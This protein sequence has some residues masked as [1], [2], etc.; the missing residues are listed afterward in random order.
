MLTKRAKDAAARLAEALD[1]SVERAIEIA[2]ED[3]LMSCG[4]AP[5]ER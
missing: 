4:D 5:K 1:V 3:A 2:L